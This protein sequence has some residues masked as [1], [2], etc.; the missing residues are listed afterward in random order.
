MLNVSTVLILPADLDTKL[1]FLRGEKS[2]IFWPEDFKFTLTHNDL[3]LL[4]YEEKNFRN[5][6]SYSHFEARNL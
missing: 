6:S 2:R 1:G 3:H 5:I 4:I